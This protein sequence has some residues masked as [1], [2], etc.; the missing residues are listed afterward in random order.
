MFIQKFINDKTNENFIFKIHK[1][2]VY[3]WSNFLSAKV[4]ATAEE[5]R[6]SFGVMTVK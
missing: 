6:N 1:E 2:E 3:F 5:D 4:T